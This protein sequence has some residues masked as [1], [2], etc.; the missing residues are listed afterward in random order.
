MARKVR[1]AAFTDMCP[2]NPREVSDNL[3]W[4][5]EILDLLAY[6]KP[7]VVCL[8]ETFDTRSTPLNHPQMAQTL[9]DA[10]FTRM[11]AKAREHRFY[12]VC[13]FIEKRG[14]QIFNTAVVID[15]DGHVAGRYDKIHP[16]IGEIED[17]VVPG[18]TAPTTIETD[19]GR[20]GCQICF[21][22]NWPN[23]WRALK[24]AGAEI[25]FF[26][27]AFSAGRI[28]ESIATIFHIPIVAACAHPCC[29]IIDR[30][31]L[32]VNRQGVYQKWVLATLDL[33]NSL[34]H[35]DFQFEKMEEV[36]RA[37]GPDVVVRVYEEEGWWRVLPQR[38][39]LDILDIIHRFELEPL[40]DY[41]KRSA[42]V[43]DDARAAAVHGDGRA[44]HRY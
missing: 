12:I 2:K 42:R 23:G 3:A 39:D 33:D 10:T 20:I 44:S 28:L 21:D 14:N 18:D 30:D 15:R 27:S 31:G 32:T 5:S 37:Y 25:I 1:V 38:E 16:T 24:E 9:E 4:T 11:A 34:F 7:D 35:L 6:E 36:R 22:A 26:P 17:E 29:R 19:F 40:E 43:Q 8:T 13:A 41:F